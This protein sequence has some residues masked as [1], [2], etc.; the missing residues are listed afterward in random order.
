MAFSFLAKRKF[1][2]FILILATLFWCCPGSAQDISGQGIARAFLCF[3]NKL[4]YAGCDEAYRLNPTGNINVPP[5]ATDL[6]CNGPCLTETQLVL[7]CIDNMLSNFLFYNK[8][9]VP[10]IRYALN[11]GC[12]LIRQ[13]GN[14]NLGE[15]IQGEISSAYKLSISI[16]FHAFLLIG[17][18]VVNVT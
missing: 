12:S 1:L 5:E 11:V 7:N 16:G 15:Y 13:R 14:F 2:G 3:N 18:V 8:A 10:Q 6:F 17:A 9:T 4:I